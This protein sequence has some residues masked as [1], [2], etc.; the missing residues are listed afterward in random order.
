MSLRFTRGFLPQQTLLGCVLDE[1]P[2]QGLFDKPTYL[3]REALHLTDS[4]KQSLKR[5]LAGVGGLPAPH[6]TQLYTRLGGILE[7]VKEL[8]TGPPPEASP[9]RVFSDRFGGIFDLRV[10]IDD[11]PVS[12]DSPSLDAA[13]QSIILPLRLPGLRERSVLHEIELTTVIAKDRQY[14]VHLVDPTLDP[15]I[16]F[17]YRAA[18]EIESAA[19]EAFFNRKNPFASKIQHYGHRITLRAGSRDDRAE[20]SVSR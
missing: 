15:T 6:P 13:H 10:R 1:D 8:F 12:V 11:Q 20:S 3:F 17:D 18:K 5:L 19:V 2:L 14:P 4:D 7:S 9:S 16:V